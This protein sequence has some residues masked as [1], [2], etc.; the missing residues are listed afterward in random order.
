MR[1]NATDVAKR[2]FANLCPTLMWVA[3][4]QYVRQRWIEHANYCLDAVAFAESV[5]ASSDMALAGISALP[6]AKV[7]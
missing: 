1:E 6:A 2:L 7:R 3:E 4:P 5:A